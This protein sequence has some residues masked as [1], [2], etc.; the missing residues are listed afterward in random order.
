MDW[1]GLNNGFVTRLC[2]T[3]HSKG[4]GLLVDR[5]LSVR[6]RGTNHI[7]QQSNSHKQHLCLEER[8]AK[9][10]VIIGLGPCYDNL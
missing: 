3:N 9:D 1:F 2:S 7:A 10:N 5:V 8:H 6:S 4:K